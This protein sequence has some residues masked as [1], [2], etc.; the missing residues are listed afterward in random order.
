MTRISTFLTVFVGLSLLAANSASAVLTA[1]PD[2]LAGS[3]AGTSTASHA[4]VRKSLNFGHHH[5]HR[6]FVTN[7]YVPSNSFFALSL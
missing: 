7:D 3:V 1:V 2:Q 4:N 6:K 5:N